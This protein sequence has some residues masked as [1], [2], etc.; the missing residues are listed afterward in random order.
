MRFVL[1]ILTIM[2]FSI[3][4]SWLVRELGI[5]PQE[6]LEKVDPAAI[7]VSEPRFELQCPDGP[8][9]QDIRDLLA[10][11]SGGKPAFVRCPELSI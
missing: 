2:T 3:A 4:S 10:S 11:V 8:S 9:R 7:F 1:T 5:V 6:R